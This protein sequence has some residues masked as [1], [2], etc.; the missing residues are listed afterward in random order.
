MRRFL[1]GAATFC[2]VVFGAL[3]AAEPVN[4]CYFTNWARYRTGLINQGKDVLEMQLDGEL[5]THFMYGFATVTTDF[6]I[7]SNDPNA[8]HPSGSEAQGELC[9]AACNDPSFKPDWSDASGQRCD[10]PCNPSRVMRGYEGLT[11]GM[12]MK[13]PKIKTLISVGGW[14]FNDCA[15]S[16]SATY[17]QG[18]A[19]CEIF[20]TIASSE[21]SIRTFAANVIEFCRKWGFDGFDLDWEYPVVAG[22]N[23]NQ[24]VDGKFTETSK[25][26]A[27]YI[28]MLRVMKEEFVRENAAQP[29][30]LMAAVGVGKHTADT[31]YNIPAMNQHLDLINLMTYDLHGA[32]ESRTG[33]NA[34]LYA[35]KEDTAIGGGVG[36]GE[37]VEG[38]PLSV[39]WAVDYWIDHGASPEK[40]TMGVGTYGRGW[41]LAD[42]S[43]AGYNAPASGASTPGVSTKE[44]GYK[45]YYEI[46]NLIQ[47]GKAVR[48]YDEE[49]E[50]PYIVTDDGEWIGYDDV[51]SLRAK[52]EFVNLRGLRGTMVWALDLD[53]FAGTYS[54]SARYPLISFVRQSLAGSV[55]TRAPSPVVQPPSPAPSRQPF[56]APTPS[57]SGGSPT[58][59]VQAPS[60]A[61]TP[62]TVPVPATPSPVPASP[63]PAVGCGSCDSCEAVPNNIQGASNGHCSPCARDGQRWWPCNVAGL[64]RCAGGAIPTTATTSPSPS[65]STDGPTEAPPTPTDPTDAPTSEPAS[66]PSPLPESGSSGCGQCDACEAVPG[67]VQSATDAHC[68]PCANGG[69]TWW[70]CN[71]DGLCRCAGG[72]VGRPTKEPSVAPTLSPDQESQAPS[73]RPTASPAPSSGCS[74]CASCE[75]VPGNAQSA[76]DGHCSPCANDG[77][78]WWPCNVEGLCRCSDGGPTTSLEPP[79]ASPTAAPR[80]P[81]ASTSDP[82]SLPTASTASDAPTMSP[83]QVSGTSSPTAQPVATPTPTTASPPPPPPPPTS[84]DDLVQKALRA[85]SNADSSG[86]FM[87]DTGSGWLESDIYTWPDM[88]D[89]VR[90]MA[91]TGVGKAKLW[92]GE[93]SN[94]IYGLVNV[95]AF[96]AQSMQ[97]TIQYNACDENNWSDKAV[98]AEAGGS[99]YS[100]TAAC[101]QLHQSYQDYTCSRE[102]DDIA[103]GQMACDVDP[104]MEARA[105]TQAGW[106][107]APAKLFCAPRSKVPK[108]PRWDYSSPW[109]APPGGWGHVEP[110]S[111]NISLD[112]Y[113]EYVNSGGSCKDY[114]GI[115]TGGWKFSGEG[116]VNGACPGSPAPLFGKPVGRTDVE[117]CCWWGR[118][119]IQTTG[120]C[121]FGKLNYYLG[122]RAS[123]EG[124]SAIYPNIDFCRDPGAICRPGGPGEL[125]WVAGLFYWLN[126]VQP[127]SSASGWNYLTELKKWVDG[128]RV[129][130]DHGFIDGASGIVN[131]GCHNPPNCGTGELHGGASRVQNFHKVLDAMGL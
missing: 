56:L 67:N 70:P 116:C 107:G 75:A 61:P 95:A 68:A 35:T 51:Q 29:L 109:C 14:N 17:G 93:G 98:V 46:L 97:E 30:L 119:V 77:Q 113:F 106:Y 41:K 104:N 112:E 94:H 24:K 36:A 100:S 88:I 69:Q 5:C 80:P 25:D 1:L 103:G 82:T 28:T 4:V 91:T 114:E 55:S 10:W 105:Y 120:V 34:N 39:S 43:R 73:I 38:Y 65:T 44:A 122:N 131:R 127:Y 64:C 20:S 21:A 12:K 86:V 108:A 22:H 115:K 32:W 19:T 59:P 3:A 31:A 23:D 16:A 87:Y 125:K 7:K 102:E 89:A 45:A 128:G 129:R 121:N 78:A 66:T 57:P 90:L 63:T 27:N 42:P 124:R 52:M 118:G 26:Y 58:L 126:A 18:T 117:G 33:C 110:F 101:G 76:T 130:S 13:N 111:D 71:V 48:Y 49:R 96:L 9:P 92:L 84:D 60:L 53:D 79:S 85:L 54:D 2:A 40:L 123:R 81:T 62:S 6:N 11:V 50:C 72:G 99:T 37:A 8:D 83:S 15:A 47:S 74:S